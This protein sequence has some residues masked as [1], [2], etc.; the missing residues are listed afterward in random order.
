MENKPKLPKS[1]ESI[2]KARLDEVK[3]AKIEFIP[4]FK[5]NF[6]APRGKNT[7]FPPNLTSKTADFIAEIR[8]NRANLRGIPQNRVS[9]RFDVNLSEPRMFC[10]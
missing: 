4:F 7:H 2:E 9:R 8:G 3:S 6:T 5:I 10:G 1:V